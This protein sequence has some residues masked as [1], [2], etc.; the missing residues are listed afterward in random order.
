MLT[1]VIQSFLTY[2]SPF[3]WRYAV[4]PILPYHLLEILDA[5]VVTIIGIHSDLANEDEF[6]RVSVGQM[7]GG[8][9]F[10]VVERDI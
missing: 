7:C 9:D 6:L 4:V 3:V 8:R 1:Y 5:P 10:F 2:I